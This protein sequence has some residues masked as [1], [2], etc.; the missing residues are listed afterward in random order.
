[1]LM[2]SPQEAEHD[3]RGQDRQRDRDRDDQRA[4]P[5]PQEEQDHQGGE[6][7]RDDRLA[8]HAADR[9]RARRWTD[10]RAGSIFSSGGSVVAT[11]GST[12]A[13]AVHHVERGGIAGLEHGEQRA[14]PAVL[15]HDVGLRREAV[16]H[17][18]DVAQVDGGVAD[19]LDRQVVQLRHR[20][21]GRVQ[22]HVVLE[23]ADLG[24]AGRQ[25]Q[26]LQVDGVEHVGRGQPLRLQHARV[27]VDHHLPLL[28]AVRDTEWPRPGP[29]RA[30]SAGS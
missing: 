26:V 22:A 6:A 11:R 20:A 18:G 16:A 8:D 27:Q 5:A 29:S 24:G 10:R 7:R 14:A 25:H 1:M 13:D 2:V 21:G 19:H 23:L 3:H 15:P 12:A 17:V 9:R 4:A 28:A 30:G